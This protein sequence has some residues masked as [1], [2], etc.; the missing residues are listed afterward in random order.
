MRTPEFFKFV[1]LT[2][3]MNFD[4]ESAF[5]NGLGTLFLKSQVQIHDCFIRYAR[6]S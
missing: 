1:F 4:I 6:T 2:H 5:S 3:T